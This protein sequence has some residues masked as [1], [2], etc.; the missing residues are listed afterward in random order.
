MLGEDACLRAAEVLELLAV[1]GS[2]ECREALRAYVRTG[3]HWVPV[4]ESVADRW[5]SEWWEDLADVAR[6][7]VEREEE[8]PW[9]SEPWTRFGI[10]VQH[11]PPD[12]GPSLDGLGGD[13]LLALLADTTTDNNTKVKALRALGRLAPSDALLPLVP[14]LGTPDG[15]RALPRLRRAIDRLGVRALPAA[16]EWAR[17]PQPWLARLGEDILADHPGPEALPE[18]VE[19]LAGQWADRVWCGPDQTA[20]RLAR[21]GPI[22]VDAVPYLRRYWWQTPHSYERAAY[23]EALASIDRNGLEYVYT[24]GCAAAC[25]AWCQRHSEFG[26]QGCSGGS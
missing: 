13:E 23:V 26:E 22:A 9:F 8:L 6:S 3:P 14:L 24:E 17:D 18:L 15:R 20:R 1:A 10:E 2:D 12:P 21:L 19:E 16:R 7:R 5:P 25:R 4:L 11:I